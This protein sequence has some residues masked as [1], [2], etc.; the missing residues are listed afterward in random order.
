MIT[1]TVKVNKIMIISMKKY[2]LRSPVMCI[3][4]TI[5]VAVAVVYDVSLL[6]HSHGQLL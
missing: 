6:K 3:A 5:T 2:I 1:V 4:I